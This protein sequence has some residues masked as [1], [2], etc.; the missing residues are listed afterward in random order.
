MNFRVH[1]NWVRKKASNVQMDSSDEKKYVDSWIF[2]LTNPAYKE[3]EAIKAWNCKH[4]IIGF[5][6]G[7]DC[8]IRLVGWVQWKCVIKLMHLRLY[9][10]RIVW[11][12][13]TANMKLYCKKGEQSEEEWDEYGENGPMYGQNADFFEKEVRD[14]ANDEASD[15]FETPRPSETTV[16]VAACPHIKVI[17]AD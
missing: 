7:D 11:I 13:A 14:I 4:L 12:I 16:H 5:E 17:P 3:I 8:P 9:N 6:G 15:E 10:K 2:T 1:I